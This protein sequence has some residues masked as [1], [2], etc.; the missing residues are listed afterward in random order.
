[1]PQSTHGIDETGRTMTDCATSGACAALN[2]YKP[3]SEV[4]RK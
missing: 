1:M 4:R 3:E 2:D